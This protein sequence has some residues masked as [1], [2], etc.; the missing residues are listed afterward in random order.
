MKN[1]SIILRNG[2]KKL[3][4][5]RLNNLDVALRLSRLGAGRFIVLTSNKVGFYLQTK[6]LQSINLRLINFS[7]LTDS[8][9]ARTIQDV[10][11]Y[12]DK[13]HIYI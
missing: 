4:D 7:Y 1:L 13:L 2:R 6:L 3:K 12:L 8:F 10:I 5:Q 11:Y 9:K